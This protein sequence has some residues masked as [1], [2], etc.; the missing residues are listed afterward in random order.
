MNLREF[1]QEIKKRDGGICRLCRDKAEQ[2]IF[3]TPL[4]CGGKMTYDNALMICDKCRM[5]FA[6]GYLEVNLALNKDIYD[7]LYKVA[8]QVGRGVGEIIRQLISECLLG[9]I[10]WQRIYLNHEYRRI[11]FKINR[12]IYEKFVELYADERGI[13]N[14]L[15]GLV[16]AYLK[17]LKI[18]FKEQGYGS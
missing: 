1:L 5:E 10:E 13:S 4:A 17:R 6:R 2:V 15:N 12:G 16:V 11:K 8:S 7:A 3:V 18:D 9:C 14:V